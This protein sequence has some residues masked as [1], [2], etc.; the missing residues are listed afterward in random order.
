MNLTNKV[1]VISGAGSGIGRA[2]SLLC[3]KKGAKLAISDVDN[4]RLQETVAMIKNQ[5]AEVHNQ[6][7]DVSD[8]DA[9]QRYSDVVIQH[10]GQV[11]VVLNNAGVTLGSFSIEEVSIEQFKWVMDINFWGMV[12]GTKAFLT[13]LKGRPE[14]AVA[15][16]SSILGLGAISDQGPYCASKFGIRGF[17][18]SLRM[19]AMI[20]FPHVN[21]LSIHPGGIQTNIARDANWGDKE[22]SQAEQDKMAKEFEKTFINT[23]DYAATTIV[24]ALEKK[25]QRLLIGNDA[26]RMW[27]VINWFPVSYT[28]KLY[29]SLIKDIDVEKLP[30]KS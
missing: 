1:V 3:A 24:D 11:D 28:K 18:E 7:L 2:T 9:W 20:D 27:R 5:G 6:I 4:D 22:I 30:K 15:N 17:T 21:V 16:I 10:F 19:E 29:N 26:K 13:H 23:A 14:A 12:Y 25:K 8:W